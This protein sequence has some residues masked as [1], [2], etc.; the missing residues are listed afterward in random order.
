MRGVITT[1]PITKD[2][3]RRLYE[4]ILG[5]IGPCCHAIDYAGFFK[6]GLLGDKALVIVAAPRFNGLGCLDVIKKAVNV[7]WGRPKGKFPGGPLTEIRGRKPI[8]FHWT[9]QKN[10]GWRL[11]YETGT[12]DFV[13][14]AMD[15]WDSISRGGS[16]SREQLVD[17]NGETVDTPDEATVFKLLESPF[18]PPER[19][20]AKS[21]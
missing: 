15:H 11:F 21:V 19:R 18:I 13:Q 3:M 14:R 16:S 2:D 4:D 1:P 8:D 9:M 7:R 17:R 5:V 12:L 20:V 6:R 10:F